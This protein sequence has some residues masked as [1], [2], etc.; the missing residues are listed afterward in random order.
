MFQ[1]GQLRQIKSRVFH[2]I[3]A[4]STGSGNANWQ[5]WVV[6]K[7]ARFVSFLLLGA[8]GGG[9]AGT[10]NTAG[11]ASGGSGA[12][13]SAIYPARALPP[14]IYFNLVVGGVGASTSAGAGGGGGNAAGIS[15]GVSAF[16]TSQIN[17]TTAVTIILFASSGSGASGGVGGTGGSAATVANIGYISRALM[18]NFVAGSAGVN[19][20]TNVT[21]T[22]PVSGGA[23]GSSGGAGSSVLA[24]D[25]CLVGGSPNTTVLASG[26][27]TVVGTGTQGA[28]GHTNL[29]D[30][31]PFI[32]SSIPWYSI[33]GAGGGAGTGGSG[34]GGAGGHGA[35]GSGGG[36]AG[37]GATAVGAGGNGGSAFCLIEWW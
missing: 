27:A 14:T 32:S 33:G 11:G 17:S 15:T 19:P 24:G 2:L 13:S 23:G 28:S 22:I 3:G 34:I 30:C 16:I 35:V 18:F 4:G 8:G 37:V 20:A 31:S 21:T 12:I 25:L 7:E 29:L 9:G 5:S 36:G 6:P 10:T 26:G 1:A